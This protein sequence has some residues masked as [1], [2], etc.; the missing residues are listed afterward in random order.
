[1]R[2]RPPPAAPWFN[3]ETALPAR[4]PSPR[5]A[6]AHRGANARR[7]WH[8]AAADRAGDRGRLRARSPA[9]RRPDRRA[10][11]RCAGRAAR[12]QGNQRGEQERAAEKTERRDQG[13]HGERGQNEQ[14]T[15]QG[16][17]PSP[18]LAGTSGAQGACSGLPRHWAASTG[19]R[20]GHWERRHPAGWVFNRGNV[21]RHAPELKMPARSP[22]GRMQDA[23]APGGR[24]KEGFEIRSAHRKPLKAHRRMKLRNPRGSGRRINQR[25]SRVGAFGTTAR[26]SPLTV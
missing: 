22:A 9:N 21:F 6:A 13:S 14:G 8:S 24:A 5:P 4:R 2:V 11:G 18:P 16:S 23:G 1:M 3:R 17:Q 7:A 15:M 20:L 25:G 19:R 26:A 10:A 12:R